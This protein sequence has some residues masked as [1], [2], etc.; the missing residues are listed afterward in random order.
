MMT[1]STIKSTTPASTKRSTTVV[2]TNFTMTLSPTERKKRLLPYQNFYFNQPFNRP[3]QAGVSSQQYRDYNEVRQPTKN[4]NSNIIEYRPSK[5]Y[6]S[7][8]KYTPFM[9]SNAIPGPF[10]P[11]VSSQNSDSP[12]VQ[13][14]YLD[15]P[16]QEESSF[17][18]NKE[19]STTDLAAIYEKLAQLKLRQQ[20][21]GHHKVPYGYRLASEPH[22]FRERPHKITNYDPPRYIQPSKTTI[23]TF[24]ATNIDISGPNEDIRYKQVDLPRYHQIP[25]PTKEDIGLP[26]RT[27]FRENNKPFVHHQIAIEV[28]QSSLPLTFSPNL[29]RKP[30]SNSK[31][32]PRTHIV[33]Q[34][35]KQPTNQPVLIRKPKPIALVDE[36]FVAEKFIPINEPQTHYYDHHS[37]PT[38]VTEQPQYLES[39]APVYEDNYEARYQA[40]PVP[41]VRYQPKYQLE[42]DTEKY[43][44]N[45]LERIPIATPGP[46]QL[47]PE[48]FRYQTAT[49]GP[50]TV[51]SVTAYSPIIKVTNKKIVPQHYED[52]SQ[53]YEEDYHPSTISNLVDSK[54]VGLAEILKQL[55]ES[56]TLP[57]TLTPNNIDNSIKT[58]VKIL[59]ALKDRQKQQR[60]TELQEEYEYDNEAGVDLGGDITD[61]PDGGTPGK[62]GVDYPA[63]SSIPKTTF[64]CKTQRYKGFF[65]DPDTNC[66]VWHYCDLNGGQA[67]FLCPN[68]TIFS[69]VALTCDW[70]F[71]VKC[72][73][74]AQLYVL[75]ERLY[76]YIIPLSPKF[77]EDYSGPLVDKYLAMKFQEME[78]KLKKEKKGKGNS[79]SEEDDESTENGEDASTEETRV[80]AQTNKPEVETTTIS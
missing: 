47:P 58:L 64:S 53:R 35:G 71:N 22:R 65:G 51:S 14:V 4:R 77:P 78:E 1:I 49:P 18:N 12:K 73:S 69:Q 59:N 8:P 46:P 7:S 52:V 61:T 80:V 44:P 19:Q 2:P 67:S 6:Q 23:E 15:S 28:P 55:Q 68:G 62:P 13:Y 79:D 31:D 25:T 36:S 3:H 45:K 41:A 48:Y 32:R 33:I 57:Q 75:N 38:Y 20:S 26:V 10:R 17:S 74:T 70:W 42:D 16:Y 11:M 60:P 76:K 37:R 27:K 56:N 63:L 54:N 50:S 39:P 24:T 72:S 40:T 66:Q 34:Q 9:E 21:I 30:G 5:T 43:L 29:I